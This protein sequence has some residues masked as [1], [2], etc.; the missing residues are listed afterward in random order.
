MRVSARESLGAKGSNSEEGTPEPRR[1]PC[2]G[3]C[4]DF[5]CRFL[6]SGVNLVAEFISPPKIYTFSFIVGNIIPKSAK[7]IHSATKFRV[8]GA[9]DPAFCNDRNPQL[10]YRSKKML[11]LNLS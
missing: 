11:T 2:H 4:A 8:S 3:P 9:L 7:C 5:A 10:G 6:G 1:D